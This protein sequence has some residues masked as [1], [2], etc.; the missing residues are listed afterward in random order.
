MGNERW[1]SRKEK[2]KIDFGS[3][4]KSVWGAKK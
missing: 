4:E 1:I 3:I 2:T